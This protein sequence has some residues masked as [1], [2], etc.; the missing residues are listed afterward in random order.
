MDLY[1]RQLNKGLSS[2][3]RSGRFVFSGS[4]DLPAGK[5]R[6]V[7]REGIVSHILGGWTLAGQ[8]IW[9]TGAPLTPTIS[10][11]LCFCG[12]GNRP[13]RVGDPNTGPKTIDNWF[14][15]A[16]FQHPGNLRFG[17]SAPGVIIGPSF[18]VNDFS[19]SKD[20]NFTES[21]RLN[22]RADFFNATNLVNYGN[23]IVTIF[24]EGQ[25]GTTN[26][27]RSAGDPRRIQL[28]AKFIF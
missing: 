16:A 20:F 19:L 8:Y 7:F 3:H 24:P 25:P 5:G 11:N 21:K 14:N 12:A 2:Q 6:A 22:V 17:N 28:G 9:Q 27:I 15:L 10:P 13:N 1:N 26:I 18:K 4:Y 23:P